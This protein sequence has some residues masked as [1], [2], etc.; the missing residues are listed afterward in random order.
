MST[1]VPVKIQTC[2]LLFLWF[3]PL[4]GWG[5]ELDSI[6]EV[7]VSDTIP[8]I[9][10]DTVP[11]VIS[12]S[13]PAAISDSIPEIIP[14]E[15]IPDTIEKRFWTISEFTG[16][17]TPAVP[18]TVLTDYFHRTNVEG[19]GT[20]IG[21]LGNLGSPMESRIFSERA[22]RSDFMFA[23]PF[24]AYTKT[25]EKFQFMNIKIPSSVVSYQSG[26]GNVEEEERFKALVAT[27]LGKH[28][29]IGADVDYLYARGFYESQADKRIDWVG[30]ANYVSDR[31]QLHVFYHTSDIT[32]TENGGIDGDGWITHPDTMDRA[33]HSSKEI[34][35]KLGSTWSNQAGQRAYLNYRYSFGMQRAHFV[36][37]A[38][39]FY[40][41]DYQDKKRRFY[42]TDVSILDN[43]YGEYTPTHKSNA[44]STSFFLMHNTLGLSL[45]EG[46]AD[47]AKWDLAAFVTHEYA[48]Y[49]ILG[50]D[51]IAGGDIELPE[52]SLFVGGELAKNK[53]AFLR[54]NA[55]FNLGIIGKKKGNLSL[56]GTVE[57]RIPIFGD[58][59]SVIGHAALSNTAPT[60][61]ENRYN[62]KYISWGDGLGGVPDGGFES[63]VRQKF[64]GD[65]VIPHTDT[66][67]GIEVENI[68]NYIYFGAWGWPVQ[69]SDNIQVLT[70]RLDQN[71]KLGVLHWDSR[72]VYQKSSEAEILPLPDFAA[73]TSLYV[74]FKIAKVL[75]VQLGANAHYWTSYYAPS[76]EPAIQ[77]FKLQKDDEDDPKTKVGNYPLINAFVN[78]HLKQTR[79]FIEWYNVGTL[80]LNVPPNYFSLPHYPINPDVIKIGL[81][82]NFIN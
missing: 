32:T 77:Q 8:P 13:I 63:V 12:D 40:T 21:Y 81:S 57:T 79:F 5:Q 3:I 14:E 39:A 44:D 64:G 41:I 28:F 46:F 70:G 30:F 54:Y 35:V 9:I 31:H 76:Y 75:T 61:Y 67:F 59:A 36:P 16:E 53:G 69:Y 33:L 60:F 1:F 10:T 62:S 15:I 42:T 66:K 72:L 74:Q 19:F 47:W 7:V 25:P 38:T 26:G 50:Q 51:S 37:V 49:R 18:D 56:S 24:Y 82:V 55:A 2:I 4:V 58:T 22:S 65:L 27:N 48:G 20:A 73:Y 45:R 68:N 71:F 80:L 34:P 78:A 29:N 17:R 11:P 6:P 23:D 43:Y 52:Q